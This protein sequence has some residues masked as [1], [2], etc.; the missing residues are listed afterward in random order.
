MY[1][2]LFFIALFSA[3]YAVADQRDPRLSDLF[4]N[5]QKTKNVFEAET[6]ERLIWDI[7]LQAPDLKSDQLMKTGIEAMA[8]RNYAVA[9]KNFD[10]LINLYPDF[11]EGWYKRANLYYLMEDYDQA[12]QNLNQTLMLE[13]RHFG[14]LSLLGLIK[15]KQN[16]ES[17]ALG[18]YEKVLAIH[19]NMNGMKDRV[20]ELRNLIRERSL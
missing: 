18:N 3:S 14:A 16:L 13:P 10:E 15:V 8:V 19:P 1:R 2:L 5:L 20:E 9:L 17:D 7:W 12:I 6:T 11:A 4:D